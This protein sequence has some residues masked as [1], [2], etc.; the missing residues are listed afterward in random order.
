M[1]TLSSMPSKRKDKPRRAGRPRQ[2]DLVLR[3]RATK[4]QKQVL[5]DAAKRA[6]LDLSDWMRATL[7]REA[8]AK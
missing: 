7:L 1:A 5:E 4:A 8:G 2:F 6:K 3:F